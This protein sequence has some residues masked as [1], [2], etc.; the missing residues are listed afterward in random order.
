MCLEKR[1]E[2]RALG[3]GGNGEKTWEGKQPHVG[4]VFQRES[5]TVPNAAVCSS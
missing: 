3:G 2:D 4:N 5:R 1:S